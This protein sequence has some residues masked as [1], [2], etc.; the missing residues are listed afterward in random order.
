M[1]VSKPFFIRILLSKNYLLLVVVLMGNKFQ[2]TSHFPV[3]KLLA[4]TRRKNA[5]SSY[6]DGRRRDDGNAT[7]IRAVLRCIGLLSGQSSIGHRH[8]SSVV[9]VV[10]RSFGCSADRRLI[11]ITAAAE[12]FDCQ[13]DIPA[14]KVF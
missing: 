7:Q 1:L 11:F 13:V 8:Q 4:E 9:L 3:R 6:G 2:G 10:V 14:S 12:Q 5:Q